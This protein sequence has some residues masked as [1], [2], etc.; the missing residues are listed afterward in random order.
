MSPITFPFRTRRRTA[1]LLAAATG[2]CLLLGSLTYQALFAIHLDTEQRLATQRL[3][4]FARSLEATIARH[5]SLPGLLALDPSLAALLLEPGNA[6]R[7]A[8]ANAYL[9]SAQQ[10]ASVAATFLIDVHGQTVAAS[11]WRQPRSFIGHNYAFRPYFRDALA[12][13]LGRFYGVGVTTGEPGYFLAAPVRKGTQTLGVIVLKVGLESMEQALA[14]G[15]DTLLLADAD[16]VVF[17]S[18]SPQLRYRTLAPLPEAVSIRLADTRQYGPHPIT[19]LADHPLTAT[20]H[21]PLRLALPGEASRERLIHTRPVGSLGWQIVQL[22]DPGEARA[23]AFAGGMA[24]AFAVAFGLGLAG[25]VRLRRQRREELRR[26][27]AGLE[28]RIAERTADLIN[29]I[30]ELEKT[31]AI[32]R[33][34]RDTAVQAGKLATLG[35]MSAG[36]SHE[37]NQPLAALQTFA[38]NASALLA[39]GRHAEVAENLQMI[40]QL[41]DRTGRIVRQL[42]SFARKEAPTPQAVSVASAIEHAQLIVE[43]RRRELNAHIDNRAANKLYAIAETGRVEQILVNLLRNGLDAMAGQPAPMLIIHA[44]RRDDLIDIVV[45]DHGPGLSAEAQQHLFEPFYTTKPAGEGL[46][47]GLAISQTIAESYGGT[48][49]VRNAPEGGAEFVLTL[50]AA[51]ENHAPSHP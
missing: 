7:Q 36:I 13:G 38:D 2:L 28:Q 20:H 47:L 15:G 35:Q 29:Q 51:G 49:S 46:G 25:H 12:N 37:L 32:L 4:A 33:E 22:G 43:P 24:T 3:D 11:N 27:H 6:Q 23:T 41:V 50:P 40:S 14:N 44:L 30:A 21:K 8:A 45:R 39:R 16:G 10:G 19:P 42:K 17:L 5:E 34:T 9:E 1:F 31:K 26:I 48:L 18:S